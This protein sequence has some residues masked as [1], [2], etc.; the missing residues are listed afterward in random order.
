MQKSPTKDRIQQHIKKK[1]TKRHHDQVGFIPGMQGW[2]NIQ[3]PTNVICPV[4]KIKEKTQ[5]P[6]LMQKKHMKN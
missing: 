6:Q 1:N 4:K 5:L 3:Q 2:F